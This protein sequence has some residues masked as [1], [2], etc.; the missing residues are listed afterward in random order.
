MEKELD[1]IKRQLTERIRVV[2]NEEFDGNKTR[3]ANKVGCSEKAIRLLFD[4][5]SGMSLNLLLK[6]SHAIS[7]TPS[8]LLEGLSLPK[9]TKVPERNKRKVK[10]KE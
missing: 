9:D 8:E 10:K 1:E 7:K 6:I 2:F 4:F 5:D 3:F